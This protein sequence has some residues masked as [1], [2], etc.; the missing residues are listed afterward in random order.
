M[1]VTLQSSS[2]L[3]AEIF[4]NSYLVKVSAFVRLGR[5]SGGLPSRWWAT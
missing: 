2:P 4:D 3:Y 5:A 1:R